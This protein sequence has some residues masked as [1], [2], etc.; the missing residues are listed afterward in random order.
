MDTIIGERMDQEMNK[1]TKKLFQIL[2]KFNAKEEL[3]NFYRKIDINEVIIHNGFEFYNI[4]EHLKIYDENSDRFEKSNEF[5]IGFKYIGMGHIY[6]L[7]YDKRVRKYYFR[8][9]GG[10]DGWAVISTDDYFVVNFNPRNK[11]FE[12]N[13]L[14]FEEAMKVIVNE[15]IEEIVIME[16]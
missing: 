3:Y 7:V 2:E 8:H 6:K 16:K 14:T 12:K 11:E 5:N 4:R 15:T 10:S 9:D 1:E 13:M